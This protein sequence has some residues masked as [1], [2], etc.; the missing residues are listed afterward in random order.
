MVFVEFSQFSQW[1]EAHLND[2]AFRV[3]QN[4]LL[5]K[6]DSGDVIRGGEGL[7]KLRIALPGRGKSGGAR[8]I[9]FYWASHARIYLLYGYA[10][11]RQADLT[12]MQIQQL[13]ALMRQE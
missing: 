3:L 2:E 4:A 1:R 11:N 8:V 6:P 12:P 13:A 9:Y 10:K 5:V 7:R